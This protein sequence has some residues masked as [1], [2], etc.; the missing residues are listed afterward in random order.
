MTIEV[1]TNDDTL[2]TFFAVMVNG[3]EKF[4]FTEKFL[5]ESALVQLDDDEK[6]SAVVVPVTSDGKQVL[7][8]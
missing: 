2:Q 1:L 3:K 5:A 8:G 4:R 7:F 6:T